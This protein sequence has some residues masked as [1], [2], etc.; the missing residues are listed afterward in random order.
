M[1][2]VQK[3]Y[4]FIEIL[5]N[6]FSDMIRRIF[7]AVIAHLS[8]ISFHSR[9]VNSLLYRNGAIKRKMHSDSWRSHMLY[10]LFYDH[11]SKFRLFSIVGWHAIQKQERGSLK[12]RNVIRTFVAYRFSI[13]DYES[14]WRTAANRIFC[15]VYILSGRSKYIFFLYWHLVYITGKEKFKDKMKNARDI[16]NIW[17]MNYILNINSRLDLKDVSK[18][19]F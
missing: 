14:Y 2:T 11:T 18:L 5:Y 16:D 9:L 3:T 15:R 6:Y 10:G 13:D 4:I 17:Y 7:L 19:Q 8:F 1:S 12:W